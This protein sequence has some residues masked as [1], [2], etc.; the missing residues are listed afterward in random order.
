MFDRP[1]HQRILKLL[2][3]LD[4]DFLERSGAFF[5][6][7][8]AAVLALGEY[9]ESLDV[10]FVCSS[11]EGYRA[12]RSAVF[13][14]GGGLGEI[15]K[16]P[17]AL[18][19][20]VRAD[21]YGVRAVVDIDGVPIKFEIIREAR[22]EVSGVMNRRLQVPVLHRDDMKAEKLLANADR[23]YDLSTKSRDII[24]LAMMIDGWG[25]VSPR[26]W[27]L[28]DAAY[29]PEVRKQ[30][31]ASVQRVCDKRYLAECLA[32]MKMD[33]SHMQTVRTALGCTS[34]DGIGAKPKSRIAGPSL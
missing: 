32:A 16:T 9:R 21:Q 34:E 5:G 10:D 18:R 31:E 13:S 33:A 3:A 27:A 17:L 14:G 26:V 24:D 28:T 1:H 2:H 20:D 4:G 6:G 15:A 19:R 11:Q 8:T 25:P 29:G 30:F 22:I 23:G 7:G 12:L